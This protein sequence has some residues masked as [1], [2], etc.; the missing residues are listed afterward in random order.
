MVDK[1][2]VNNLWWFLSDKDAMR[3]AF[4]FLHIDPENSGQ[5]WP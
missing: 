1:Q 3:Q 5:H 2:S 4:I